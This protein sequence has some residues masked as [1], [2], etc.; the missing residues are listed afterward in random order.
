MVHCDDKGRSHKKNEQI[1]KKLV[2]ENKKLPTRRERL[3]VRSSVKNLTTIANDNV[4]R[5]EAQCIVRGEKSKEK[6]VGIYKKDK[7]T[8]PP[9]PVSV[10]PVKDILALTNDVVV[11]EI[12]VSEDLREE[13]RLVLKLDV[14]M[15]QAESS[16]SRDKRGKMVL[17]ATAKAL[18]PIHIFSTPNLVNPEK[19][20]S[21]YSDKTKSIIMILFAEGSY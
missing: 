5:L 9:G 4:G 16:G 2:E 1:I 14:T 17:V 13:V 7:I 11:P 10:L 19:L 8:P 12:S 3:A 18:H 20:D 21:G 15:D 6:F